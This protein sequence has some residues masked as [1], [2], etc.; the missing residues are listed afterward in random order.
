M[1]RG[2]IPVPRPADLVYAP[3]DVAVAEAEGLARKG[4]QIDFFGPLGTRFHDS[5][6]NVHTMNLR[7]LVHNNAE[8]NT[9][10]GNKALMTH[11]VPNLWDQYFARD[12]L[13]RASRGSY[14]VVHIHHPETTLAAARDHREVP[15]V[16]TL[17]DPI[18]PWY[19]ELFELYATRNQH[20]ISISNNQRRDAPDLPYLANVYD[21][22]DTH[23]FTLSE[24]SEDY[25]L[26]VG[27]IIP[28]KGIK[29]CVQIARETGNRL[30]I[31]GPTYPESQD[32]FDQYVK[33][34]LNDKILY[35][36][37]IEHSHLSKYFQKAKAFLMP[38][39]WEEPFGI[40][41]IEAMSCGTPTIALRRG[42]LPE[43]IKHGKTGYVVKS[44]GEMIKAVNR[45]DKIDRRD[46][47]EHVQQYFSNEKMVDAYEEAFLK[48]THPTA[49]LI[50]R[51]KYV[52]EQLKKVPQ[53]LRK[54]RTQ[55]E[56]KGKAKSK[57][58]FMKLK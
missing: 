40:T 48:L 45:I 14:D 5:R 29:E 49:K 55:I 18:Y 25:L 43:I 50:R 8:T 11:H 6:I 30:L 37:F 4:H 21:G 54:S 23:R 56:E 51:T 31:I 33:P 39:Q 22:T 38:S 27:R 24:T 41:T 52:G 34:F 15:I 35:L 19:K 16:Y 9:L 57:Q 1:V 28:E 2:Y 53:K 7:P 42:A 13:A 10:F 3:I 36:G 44:I 32:Y 47:R 58:I 20:F 46:C 17:H 26:Y 12:M